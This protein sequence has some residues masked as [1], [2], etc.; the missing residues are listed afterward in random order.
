VVRAVRRHVE[1][2]HGFAT[3][4]GVRITLKH[5]GGEVLGA[6][7]IDG[8]HADSLRAVVFRNVHRAAQAH[9]KPRTSPPATTEEVDNDLI[10]LR[11]EAESVL[12]FEIEGVFL[13]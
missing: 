11:V 1:P 6:G 2:A 12:G 10:V 13:L 4:F 7:V 5:V 8:V 3:A 9:F